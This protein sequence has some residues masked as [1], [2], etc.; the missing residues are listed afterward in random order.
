MSP[1]PAAGEPSRRPEVTVG[2]PGMK[3]FYCG[4][5]IHDCETRIVAA[6]EEELLQ[7]IDTHA[8]VDHGMT[9]IPESMLTEIRRGIHEVAPA[10]AHD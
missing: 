1:S 5:I 7:S 2:R 10:D 3:E 6:T 8:R 4:A 9:D